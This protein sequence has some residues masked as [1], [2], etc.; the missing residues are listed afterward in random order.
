[1]ARHPHHSRFGFDGRDL[2][3]FAGRPTHHGR[4]TARR[5][6]AETASYA[7]AAPAV[8]AHGYRYSGGYWRR[9]VVNQA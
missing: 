3:Q 8:A 9:P 2:V 1:M 7:L 6:P 5:N 4:R